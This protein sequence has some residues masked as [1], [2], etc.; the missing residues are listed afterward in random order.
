MCDA[1]D[2][3]RWIRRL[4]DAAAGGVLEKASLKRFAWSKFLSTR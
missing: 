2:V 4:A 1:T 3:R